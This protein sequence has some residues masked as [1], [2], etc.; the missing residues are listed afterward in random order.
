MIGAAGFC[1]ALDERRIG[2]VTGVPCSFFQGPI[3]LLSA[4]A[5]DRY[6]AAPNEGVAL[7]LAAGAELTGRR[8]AV[9]LQ[10]S[11]FG[12]LLNPLTSLAMPFRIPVLAFMSL[13][14]WPDSARDEPQHAVM[15]DTCIGLLQ[16]LG[17]PH[18]ILEA[19]PD[20]LGVALDEAD[21]ERARGNSYFVLVP[22]GSITAEA[23]PPAPAATFR[24]RE[25]VLAL[26]PELGDALLFATTGY[27]S[28]ELA[29]AADRPL[30]FYMQGS[31]G[32]ALGLGLGAALTHPDRRVIVLDG[33]GAALMHMGSLALTGA[34]A[35][36]RLTHVVLDNGAYESTG[37]QQTISGTVRWE[38]LG[39]ALGYRSAIVCDEPAGLSAAV[40]SAGHVPGPHLIVA[41]I[42]GDPAQVPPRV[43]SL[44]APAELAR[45]FTQAVGRERA[46]A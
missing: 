32:H 8:S 14:G 44:A 28:R 45:R 31:M 11:G 18:R 1:A 9:L 22:Q 39:P 46:A 2:F 34:A 7:A 17:V 20:G 35:P 27:I 37:S 21:R 16:V 29:A 12:N 41:R 33:D 43:T 30:N 40:R 36:T 10:N 38:Q 19:S 24:R 26:V 3:S 25:A 13:R 4:R 23:A 42:A 15:G 5:A 6:A